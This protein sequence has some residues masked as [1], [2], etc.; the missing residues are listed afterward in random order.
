MAAVIHY[1]PY[2]VVTRLHRH[3]HVR[4]IFKMRVYCGRASTAF[5]IRNIMYAQYI[6]LQYPQTLREN[7]ESKPA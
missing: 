3:I 7:I 6:H 5:S 1:F 4:V 2:R